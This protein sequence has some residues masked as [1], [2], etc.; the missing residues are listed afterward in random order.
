VEIIYLILVVVLFLLA[1]SDLVV[2]V[3]NDAVNFLSSA[4]GS[5]AGSFK[6]IIAIAG[7][8]ILAGTVFSSGMMEV[9]RKGI[10]HPEMFY[11]SEIMIIFLAVMVADVLMLDVFN[12]FGLPT[13]TTVSIVFDLLGASVGMAIIKLS[14]NPESLLPFKK[15][16]Y[17]HH[18]LQSLSQNLSLSNFINSSKALAIITGILLSVAIA[19]AVG[20][21]VQYI[22]RIIFS[23]NYKNRIKFFGAVWGGISFMVITYFILIKGAKGA[24]FMSGNMVDWIHNNSGLLL[25]YSFLGWTLL[26]QLLYWI[27]KVNI[28]RII[29]LGGTFALA[30]AFAGNDLVNF[31]GVPIAGYNSFNIFLQNP[32]ADPNMLTMIQLGGKVSIPTYFLLLAGLIMVITLY[33]SKKARSVIKTSVDLAR[34][35]AGE[36]RF[37]S[38]RISKVLVRSTI[39]FEKTVK[40]IMPKPIRVGIEKQFEPV[41]A[42]T[43]ETDPPSFDLV[44]ASVILVVSSVLIAFGT[45]LKLP[46]STTYVTFMVAMGSSL[47]DKAWGRESAVYRISGVFTVI[48]GWFLTAIIAFTAAF[49]MAFI[50]YYL[51][52]VA[53]FIMLGVVFY[54]MY[55]SQKYHSKRATQVDTQ[56]QEIRNITNENMLAKSTSTITGNLETI[57]KAYENT[58]EGLEKENIKQLKKT[59][60]GVNAVVKNVKYLKDHIDDIIEK[61]KEE[62]VDTAFYIVTVLDYMREMLHSISFIVE[63]AFEH[64]D[65]NHKP[66]MPEQIVELK[67]LYKALKELFDE[68]TSDIKDYDFHKQQ[69]VFKLIETFQK[70]IEVI[71][72]NQIKRIKKQDVGTKNSILYL[73]LINETKNLSLQAV[74]LYKSQRDF[75]NFK[76]SI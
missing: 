43:V 42:K 17:N 5:K 24:S 22:I 12:T 33:T 2:G 34:Q 48:G 25:L 18:L 20:A 65:N 3:S 50:F 44:R 21:F 14:G 41:V 71:R 45:S 55:R 8:G 1:A 75:V 10:F 58:I 19:F 39:N 74:N 67:G 16:L 29:V 56:K 35:E 37:K 54:L 70:K 47:A 59:K 73:S 61:L 60:K 9:A 32:G 69:H 7:L 64:V 30:M 51:G 72:K 49:V 68:M 26:L 13:S 52:F 15:Y 6:L 66:L 27:F 53:I 23:F 31:I 62:S 76:H 28:L 38:N 36:E 40:K 46:L 63:P 11:F 4:V 57:I